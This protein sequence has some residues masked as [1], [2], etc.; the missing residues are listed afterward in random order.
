MIAIGMTAVVM[1]VS[2][3]RVTWRM[4]RP[5]RTAVSPKKCVTMV[6]SYFSLSPAAARPASPAPGS[7]TTAKKTSSSEGCFSTYSTLAGGSSRLSSA[8]VPLTMIRPWWRIAIRSASCSASSRYWVVSSTVVPPA[9][10][11]LTACHT[12]VRASGSSPAVGSSRKMTGGFP[13]RLIAMSKR[14]RMPPE[15]IAALR[16]QRKAPQQV[17]RDRARVL[18]VP[19][20][21]DQDEVLPPAEDLV[22][23]RELPGETDGLAYVGGP[24]R[25]IEAVDPDSPCVGLE[26]RGQDLHHRGLARPV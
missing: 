19:Q 17:V 12:S 20:P 24:G 13:M 4:V 21:S 18:E 25:D 11:F 1:M 22:D 26:Q 3:L 2:G 5:V 14:R 10:S 9:A 16:R 6:I 23:R 7:P 15:Y 8:R